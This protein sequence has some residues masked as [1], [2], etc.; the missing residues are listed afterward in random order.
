M[1][2]ITKYKRE[3]QERFTCPC[4][5]KSVAYQHTS[6]VRRVSFYSWGFMHTPDDKL[7]REPSFK[8]AC[9]NCLATRKAI[10]AVPS[11]QLYCDDYPYLAYFDR[12]GRCRSCSKTFDF[13]AK[14]Q[15]HWYETLKFWVQ[16]YPVRCP[17]CRKQLRHSRGLNTQ[18]SELLK[19]GEPKDAETLLR[20]AALYRAMDKAAKALVF[21]RKAEKLR[22]KKS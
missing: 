5:S 3:E 16:S 4:C 18:L 20:A 17:S 9:D 10:P 15:L 13:S 12:K 6:A 22:R 11:N 7:L 14:E 8:W 21:E 2:K 19:N 1:K